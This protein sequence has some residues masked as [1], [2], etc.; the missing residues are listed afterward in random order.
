[1]FQSYNAI[2]GFDF[3]VKLGAKIYDRAR[4]SEK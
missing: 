1:M 3:L 4:K 2:S